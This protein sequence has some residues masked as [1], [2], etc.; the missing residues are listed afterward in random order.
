MKL[1]YF[2]MNQKFLISLVCAVFMFCASEV[3]AHKVT[4]VSV[5]SKFD[6]KARKYSIELA[7]DI[8]P[9]ED[10][11]TNE[12]VSPEQ[13]ADFFSKEALSLFF[14]DS[15]VK[16]QTKSELFKDP[17]A[18][19]EIQEVKVKVLVT[20]F[21]E[22]PKDAGHFTL[23]VSPDTTAAVVMVTFKD[24]KAGRR[25]Q[26]LYPGEFS[27]PVDVSAII[28]G[29][30]FEGVEDLPDEPDKDEAQEK[31]TVDDEGS[32]EAA[33]K[34]AFW[35]MIVDTAILLIFGAGLYY[36]VIRRFIRT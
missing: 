9:S 34:G 17:E 28:E 7:M 19:P 13:A 15:Q 11:E 12:K 18:D 25:A 30:P 20:L 3:S 10:Q 24:G 36:W 16:P 31:T 32:A 22:I 1:R 8:Y 35:R 5:V 29:D 27:S 21:G 14:G 6:T 33:D 2:K 26:V 23:R 4:A